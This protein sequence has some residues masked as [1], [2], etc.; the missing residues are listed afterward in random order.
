MVA[1]LALVA[2]VGCADLKGTFLE[3][4]HTVLASPVVQDAQLFGQAIVDRN[5]KEV[6]DSGLRLQDA[7]V[8]LAGAQTIEAEYGR[9]CAATLT[10]FFASSHVGSIRILRDSKVIDVVESVGTLRNVYAMTLGP[11]VIHVGKDKPLDLVHEV[12]HTAQWASAQSTFLLQYLPVVILG[13]GEGYEASVFE[14]DARMV[15]HEFHEE[16]P[17]V[18]VEPTLGA[19]A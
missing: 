9:E 6:H 7:Y 1:A 4:K 19:S 2:F 8:V 5:W 15:S 16:F 18:C 14:R 11:N 12:A 3:I 13:G 10:T 17:G